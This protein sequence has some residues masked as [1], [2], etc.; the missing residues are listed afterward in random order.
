MAVN[1][2]AAAAIG[3]GSL[4][5]WSGIKGWAL[6]PTLADVVSGRTPTGAETYALSSPDAGNVTGGATGGSGDAAAIFGQYIGHAYLYGGAPGPDGSK[7]WDC[8]SSCNWIVSVKM[9]RAIPG[10]GPGKYN[11]SVHGPTTLQ[12]GVW[13]GLRRISRS[14]VQSGDFI[15][16]TGH[17]GIAI[18]NTHMISALDTTDRTKETPIDGFGNGPILKYGRLV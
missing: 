14:D 9:G 17:M 10:Y 12:W 2:V 8:S 1:G 13:P 6:L 18:S 16:W 4:F 7:P 3:A 5:A 15:V 11:G